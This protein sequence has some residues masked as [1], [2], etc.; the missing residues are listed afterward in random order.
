METAQLPLEHTDGS[1][2]DNITSSN[3]FEH[4]TVYVR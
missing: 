4:Q 1:G 3:S 2:M